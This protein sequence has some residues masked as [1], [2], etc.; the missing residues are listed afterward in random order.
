MENEQLI[1]AMWDDYEREGLPG[2]L[3]HAAPDARWR[4][5]SAGGRVFQDTAEYRAEVERAM[6]AGV[7]VDSLRL[8]M[9]THGDVVVVRGR[10]RTRRGGV[11]DDTRMYW[12][13]RIRDD[14]IVW[15]SSSPDLAGLLEEAGLDRRLASEALIGLHG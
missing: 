1:V 9:W 4:P 5:Y 7:R 6:A 14:R 8:G 15:T 12:L 10:L 2:I 13:H 11:M 3:R